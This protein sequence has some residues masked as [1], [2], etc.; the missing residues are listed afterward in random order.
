MIAQPLAPD[1]LAALL[2]DSNGQQIG[3]LTKLG[4]DEPDP[5][6]GLNV[7]LGYDPIRLSERLANEPQDVP[8]T[9]YGHPTEVSTERLMDFLQLRGRAFHL[10]DIGEEP[11][12]PDDLHRLLSIP[13]SGNRS[14]YT[15]VHGTVVLGYDVPRLS[16]V[17]GVPL[18]A[19][20]SD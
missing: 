18:T 14:P 5:D 16:E 3:P 20:E 10:R 2:T 13:K 19:D 4:G 15:D 17:L 7:V 8:I 1:E 11:L 12:P 9:V 6:F